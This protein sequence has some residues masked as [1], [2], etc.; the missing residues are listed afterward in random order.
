[1]H[2]RKQK[3]DAEQWS[4]MVKEVVKT[5]K[6]A[7][8]HQTNL[9]AGEARGLNKLRKRVKDN[10]IVVYRSDKSGKMCV[11][12]PELYKAQGDKHVAGDKKV[13]WAESISTVVEG[14]IWRMPEG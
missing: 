12:T 14:K 1:M 3:T 10:E 5:Y 8:Q 6:A 13:Q 2:K 9:T 4:T 7:E 11:T